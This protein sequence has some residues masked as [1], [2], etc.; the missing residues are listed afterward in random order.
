MRFKGEIKKINRIIV[1]DPSYGK[2]VK[3]R[4]EKDNLNLKNWKVDLQ[5]YP[6]KYKNVL[7]FSAITYILL[8]TENNDLCKV[9]DEGGIS[10]NNDIKIKNYEI[11]VDTSCLALGVNDKVED[12]LKSKD[13]WHPKNAIETGGDGTYCTVTEGK[14]N[15]DIKFLLITGYS[16]DSITNNNQLLEYLTN[17]FEIE[18]M[19]IQKT[20]L[21]DI[22]GIQL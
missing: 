9:D 5:I 10:Y 12:I 4:Y 20:K 7:E 11:G 15:N 6:I 17:Q 16:D 21:K 19:V 3:C 13:I 2:E 18:N 22:E 1:S 14:K 8:L